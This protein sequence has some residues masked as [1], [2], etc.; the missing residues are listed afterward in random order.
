MGRHGFGRELFLG[1]SDQA[2]LFLIIDHKIDAK[3]GGFIR[4]E[5]S[6]TA[7]E[8][9]F[10]VGIF[11]AQL[12]NQAARFAGGILGHGA[13]VEHQKVGLFRVVDH[14]VAGDLKFS[15]PGLEFGLIEPAPKCF[16]LHPHDVAIRSRP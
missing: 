9:D 10:G 5:R 1:Q 12:S 6:V 14:A 3:C 11:P 2:M 15:G 4:F 8:N 7:A 16:E 13:T